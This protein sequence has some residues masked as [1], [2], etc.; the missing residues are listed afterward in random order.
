MSDPNAPEGIKP[1]RINLRLKRQL[2]MDIAM[3]ELSDAEIGKKYGCS[4]QNVT[5]YRTRHSD[6]IAAYRKEFAEGVSTKLIGLWITDKARRLESI[7]SMAELLEQSFVEGKALDPGTAKVYL[8][9][10]RQAAEE[11]NELKQNVQAEVR[12]EIVGVDP[13]D[14]T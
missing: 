4:S 1:W 12:Y 10:I 9:A 13:S 2:L 14:V 6:T 5:Q 3:D 8:A 7:Q 11:L